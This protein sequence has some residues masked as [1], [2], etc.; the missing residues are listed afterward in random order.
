LLSPKSMPPRPVCTK[1][2]P[3]L[4]VSLPLPRL[5]LQPPTM[6]KSASLSIGQEVNQAPKRLMVRQLKSST[7]WEQ[8]RVL[9]ERRKWWWWW[10]STSFTMRMHA[11]R[12]V[13]WVAMRWIGSVWQHLGRWTTQQ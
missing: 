3:S 11:M 13:V 9:S 2:P 7:R 10:C 8:H 5:P 1:T 12:G 6:L 4:S